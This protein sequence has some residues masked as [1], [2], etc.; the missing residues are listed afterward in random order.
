VRRNSI[1]TGPLTIFAVA[2]WCGFSDPASAQSTKKP[3]AAAST[4]TKKASPTPAKKA[5]AAAATKTRPAGTKAAAPVKT[6]AAAKPVA[7][8]SAAKP[9]AAPAKTAAKAAPKPVAKPVAKKSSA[10]AATKPVAKSKP[11]K[12]PA[13]PAA[14]KAGLAKSPAKA[15]PV[16]AA[17]GAQEGRSDRTPTPPAKLSRTRSVEKG[18]GSTVATKARSG[19]SEVKASLTTASPKPPFSPEDEEDA[20]IGNDGVADDFN[21]EEVEVQGTGEALGAPVVPAV[22]AI[23][24]AAQA[25]SPMVFVLGLAGGAGAA[26][27][28]ADPLPSSGRPTVSDHPLPAPPKAPEPVPTSPASAAVPAARA[29]ESIPPLEAPVPAQPDEVTV[30]AAAV[31]PSALTEQPPATD[32]PELPPVA[33][34]TSS[35]E[36]PAPSPALAVAEPSPEVETLEEPAVAAE[37]AVAEPPPTAADSIPFPAEPSPAADAIAAAPS[38]AEASPPTGD[39]IVETA[40]PAAPAATTAAVPEQSS[41]PALSDLADL[42]AG[43]ETLPRVSS[44]QVQEVSEA[45]QNA[46]ADPEVRRKPKATLTALAQKHL[47]SLPSGDAR[48]VATSLM[49]ALPDNDVTGETGE[50]VGEQDVEKNDGHKKADDDL[51]AARAEAES[52]RQVAPDRLA[53]PAARDEL[54]PKRADRSGAAFAVPATA[55]DLLIAA[56]AQTDFQVEERRVV[57]SGEVIM[58]N[59]RFFLTADKLIAY[60]KEN[61]SGLEF[62]E[63]QGNVVV[64]MVENGRETGSSGLAKTAVFHPETGEI[65]LKGWPQLRMG[66][67]A[68]VASAA[69]TE[70]S[71]FTDGRMKT[72]GRNQTMIVP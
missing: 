2:L 56:N 10:A 23:E 6:T 41:A 16:A 20:T 37:L 64:R 60:M 36:T 19:G 26:A 40:V 42:A 47:S 72:S 49:Q 22:S 25:E 53:P 71:L 21:L 7:K 62:A 38:P 68:H 28:T 34:V 13:K 30:V 50:D 29:A 17:R 58:K 27:L 15:K 12:A 31:A 18:S 59:E 32:R 57:F 39:P 5:P 1:L 33:P 3:A 43:L 61:Q 45:L 48:V 11:A 66:N 52:T 9:A 8:K 65:V 35:P 4:G 55:G 70:M 44:R 67:K 24:K 63:A 46:V 51:L 69:T 14:P 54:A